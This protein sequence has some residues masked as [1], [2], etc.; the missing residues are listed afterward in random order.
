MSNG[1]FCKVFS[2][3]WVCA[4]WLLNVTPSSVLAP[5]D[6]KSINQLINQSISKSIE[7][8]KSKRKMNANHTDL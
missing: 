2:G 3:G 6:M 5:S 7:I 8:H 1:I 4:G